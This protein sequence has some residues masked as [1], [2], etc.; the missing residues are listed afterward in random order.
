[1]I[2]FAE[3]VALLPCKC[4]GLFGVT[5]RYD[6]TIQTDAFLGVDGSGRDRRMWHGA[7][8]ARDP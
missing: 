6:Q 7:S 1:M 3:V 8:R 2:D 4:F 5:L